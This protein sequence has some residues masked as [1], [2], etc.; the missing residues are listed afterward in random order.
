MLSA[1]NKGSGK[2]KQLTEVV[3]LSILFLF[4]IMMSACEEKS[5]LSK[6]KDETLIEFKGRKIDLEPYFKGFPYGG[7]VMDIK[8]GKLYYFHYTDTANILM[9]TSL[10]ENISLRDGEKVSDTDFSKRN[11]SGMKYHEK[12]GCLYWSGDEKNDEKMNI[13]RLCPDNKKI[14]KLTDVEYTF[15]WSFSPDKRRIAQIVRLGSAGNRL[16]ELRILDPE[17]GNSEK[18]LQDIPSLRFSWCSPCWRPDGK[19]MLLIANKNAHRKYS[20][21]VY[22]DPENKT[23]ELLTDSSKE[24]NDVILEKKW[25][26]NDRFAYISNEDGYKNIYFYDLDKRK[27]EQFTDF[28][29]D[30]DGM[31]ILEID[32]KK[33]IFAIIN[34]PTFNKMFLFDPGN[35]SPLIEKNADLNFS[36]LDAHK[37]KVIVKGTDNLTPLKINQIEVSKDSLDI[38]TTLII[39]DDLEKKIVHAEVEKVKFPTFDKDPETGKTRMLHGYLYKPKDPLPK[40]EQIALIHSFYGGKNRYL[41]RSHIL[42]E[43]GIYI[44]SPSPRGSSG[45]GSEFKAL[46][47]RDLG[48]NEIIDIIYAGKYISEKLDIPPERIGVFGGSHGGYAVMRLLTF[49]GEVNNIKADLDWGFGMSHAGFSDIISFYEN[50]NIPDWVILEAGDPGSEAE[51][52]KDRSPIYHAD[53]MKGK[54]L[55]THGENDS[56][57]PIEGSQRFADSLKYHGKDVKFVI[58]EGQ[59]HSNKGLQNSLKFYKTWFDFLESIR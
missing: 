14:K 17:T 59:G 54:I 25:L 58:F 29:N 10:S 41:S 50:C 27:N 1:I 26:S 52:L 49:P 48:G 11:T 16:G 13:F 57:V 42:T 12:D 44:F 24:R 15:G 7:Y 39:P 2:M 47:D 33:Y 28:R 4:F 19:G 51:K 18:I 37:N 53:K 34:T 23:M 5:E 20:N 22:I 32:G 40:E 45:F 35:S 30:I 8:A 21:I 31:E 6:G 38:T 9:E 46:N 56:R 36:I 55:L 43:A 3:L